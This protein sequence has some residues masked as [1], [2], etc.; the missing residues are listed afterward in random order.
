MYAYTS[1][2]FPAYE[3][4]F[5][6]G[7]SVQ[8]GIAPEETPH[9]TPN[10]NTSMT[11]MNVVLKRFDNPDELREFD[12]GKF[13]RVSLGGM[14]IGRATYQPGWKWSEDVGSAVNETY[15]RVENVGMVVSGSATAAMANGETVEMKPGDLFYVPPSPHESWIIGNDP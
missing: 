12:K 2:L 11:D 7:K 13:E 14:T 5:T 10:K 9:L 6:L 8:R 4:R 1:S 3:Y 15:C